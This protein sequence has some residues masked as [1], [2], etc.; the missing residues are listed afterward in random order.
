L[1]VVA[2]YDLEQAAKVNSSEEAKEYHRATAAG[3]LATLSV[4]HYQLGELTT[5][6]QNARQSLNLLKDIGDPR[7]ITLACTILAQ[8]LKVTGQSIDLEDRGEEF[9]IASAFF[10][11]SPDPVN[12]FKLADKAQ[13]AA[14]RARL[15]MNEGYRGVP[16]FDV[17]GNLRFTDGGFVAEDEIEKEKRL[18][19]AESLLTEALIDFRRTNRIALEA[20]YLPDLAKLRWMKGER[21]EAIK[22]SKDALSIASRCELRLKQAEVCNLLADLYIAEAESLVGVDRATALSNAREYAERGKERAWCDGPPHCYRLAL[23]ESERLL[24]EIQKMTI[25]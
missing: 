12:P 19:E 10:M 2:A 4:I 5:A 11:S 24:E 17:F 23:N 6:E 15:L 20:D 13:L 9:K 8:V 25:V 18:V 3:A 1:K 7:E 21:A 22:I 14:E 16:D